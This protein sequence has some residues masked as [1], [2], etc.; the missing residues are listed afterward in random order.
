[1]AAQNAAA[2]LLEYG[3]VLE[4]A[5]YSQQ[6]AE[7]ARRRRVWKASTVEALTQ[8]MLQESLSR[9]REQLKISEEEMRALLARFCWF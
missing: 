7:D 9:F 4:M 6:A 8:P 1:M 2:R 5:C 3:A